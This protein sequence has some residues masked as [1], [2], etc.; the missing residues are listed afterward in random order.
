VGV[1]K[2]RRRRLAEQK[3]A[4][5]STSSTSTVGPE[6]TS[7]ELPIVWISGHSKMAALMQLL[8]VVML[9]LSGWDAG[10]S[11]SVNRVQYDVYVPTWI[12]GSTHTATV[13][14]DDIVFPNL[15]KQQQALY[16]GESQEDDFAYSKEQDEDEFGGKPF[17]ADGAAKVSNVDPL[18]Q[19]DLDALMEGNTGL[20]WMCARSAIYLHRVN[21]FFFYEMPKSI[22]WEMPKRWLSTPPV[23]FILALIIRII[24]KHVLSA[25]VPELD[26]MLTNKYENSTDNSKVLESGGESKGA[27][28][29]AAAIDP[30]KMTSMATNFVKNYVQTNFPSV[31]FVFSALRDVRQDMYVILCGVLLGMIMNTSDTNA[32]LIPFST[33]KISTDGEL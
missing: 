15:K 3:A 29:I 9:F 20:F 27:A 21:L 26:E 18:F 17:G 14:D 5:S 1:A 25:H 4:A 31:F 6:S 32:L 28:K 13:I 8:T 12:S 2:M 33:S 16:R 7:S 19:V 22:F 11:S 10:Y 23:L 24:G 30:G